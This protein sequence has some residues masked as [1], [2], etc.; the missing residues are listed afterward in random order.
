M[1]LK[2]PGIL[3]CCIKITVDNQKMQ[4]RERGSVLSKMRFTSPQKGQMG[5][6]DHTCRD[7]LQIK[8][9]KG[10]VSPVAIWCTLLRRH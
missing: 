3:K 2:H 7:E 5:K 4:K 10:M 6:Q 8:K 1:L 9:Y